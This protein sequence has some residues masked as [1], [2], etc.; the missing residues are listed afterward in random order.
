MTLNN[1]LRSFETQIDSTDR[2]VLVSMRGTSAAKLLANP[3]CLGHAMLP[4]MTTI[5]DLDDAIVYFGSK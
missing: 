5:G 1:S 2:P 3:F 4:P